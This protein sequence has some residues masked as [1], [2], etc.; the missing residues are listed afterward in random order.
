MKLDH[1]HPRF[2]DIMMRARIARRPNPILDA[3]VRRVGDTLRLRPDQA[4]HDV[5]QA[6]SALFCRSC[7]AYGVVLITGAEDIR[8]MGS[9]LTRQ[10]GGPRLPWCPAFFGRESLSRGPHYIGDLGR[11]GWCGLRVSG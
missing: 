8:V 6:G 11:C 10:C 1:Q 4:H 2:V 3:A 9:L 7:D 5:F